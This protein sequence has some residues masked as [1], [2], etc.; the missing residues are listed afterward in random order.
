[1]Q[2]TFGY[3]K[4]LVALRQTRWTWQACTTLCTTLPWWTAKIQLLCWGTFAHCATITAL[5]CPMGMCKNMSTSV[6]GKM[7]VMLQLALYCSDQ[8]LSEK[9]KIITPSFQT[10]F[11][12]SKIVRATAFSLSL[13]QICT[14]CAHLFNSLHCSVQPA[15][16]QY[17]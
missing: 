2:M 14:L 7:T 6:C 8:I 15:Q 12:L 16:P 10:F 9:I 11:D 4:I 1:M 5:N 3:L 17:F 13:D